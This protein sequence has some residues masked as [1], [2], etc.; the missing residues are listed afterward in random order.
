MAKIK[1]ILQRLEVG[2][3]AEF[4][5]K[6]R[7]SVSVVASDYGFESGKRFRCRKDWEKK[8]YIVTRTI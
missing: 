5:P 4:D 7:A 6:Q 8:K 2:D 1:E 3:T